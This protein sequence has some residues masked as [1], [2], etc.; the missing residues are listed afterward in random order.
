MTEDKPPV[1]KN[2]R[3]LLKLLGVLL[4]VFV[5]LYVGVAAT[6]FLRSQGSDDQRPMTGDTQAPV[7]AAHPATSG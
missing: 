3:R 4:G 2:P 1:L 5:L 6:A 7:E